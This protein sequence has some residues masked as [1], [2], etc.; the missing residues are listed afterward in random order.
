MQLAGFMC[1]EGH[2]FA[3]TGVQELVMIN[4][5]ENRKI[6][7]KNVKFTVLSRHM[8]HELHLHSEEKCRHCQM[9]GTDGLS[10]SCLSGYL[11]C[12][13]MLQFR[14]STFSQKTVCSMMYIN[15]RLGKP[16]GHC[17]LQSSVNQHDSV[18][19]DYITYY[20]LLSDVVIRAFFYEYELLGSG[21][22][23]D[24]LPL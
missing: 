23:L 4:Q 21:Q 8:C 12:E 9:R 16:H 10:L 24:L 13:K 2:T 14:L 20:H 5:K 11:Y 18:L 17:Y 22:T 15:H 3:L 7:S 1:L 19:Q 6:P